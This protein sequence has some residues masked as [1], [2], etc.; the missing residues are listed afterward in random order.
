MAWWFPLPSGMSARLLST[1]GAKATGAATCC[2]YRNEESKAFPGVELA[3]VR[4]SIRTCAFPSACFC[5]RG[6]CSPR[7]GNR[8]EPMDLLATSNTRRSLRSRLLRHSCEGVGLL[9]QPALTPHD[10]RG[11]LG[12]L[13]NPVFCICLGT[14][15]VQLGP[16]AGVVQIRAL[17]PLQR[18]DCMRKLGRTPGRQ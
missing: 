1:L 8:K 11:V 18:D 16:C 7:M 13:G 3:I 15:S 4:V 12:T 14:T 2:S 17:C 5:A 9:Q 6:L 10:V